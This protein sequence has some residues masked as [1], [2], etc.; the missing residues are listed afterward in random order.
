[1]NYQCLW[2]IPSSIP[3]PNFYSHFL[4]ILIKKHLY[5]IIH[6]S[7][8]LNTQP[9]VQGSSCEDEKWGWVFRTGCSPAHFQKNMSGPEA[10]LLF[11][12]NLSSLSRTAC[13]TTPTA[14]KQ[15][16]FSWN[17][18]FPRMCQIKK[19]QANHTEKMQ[20]QLLTLEMLKAAV[21]SWQ[22]LPACLQG[23]AHVHVESP[24]SRRHST[25]G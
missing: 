4:R 16:D 3:V 2:K 18:S 25:L 20:D 5:G 11:F 12:T 13:R 6:T 15:P 1:M 21:L 23:V 19:K 17:C 9:L 22:E 7:L 10:E 24:P 14:E 8:I